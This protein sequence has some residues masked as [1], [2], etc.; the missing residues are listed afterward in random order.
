MCVMERQAST[1]VTSLQSIMST[2]SAGEHASPTT[3]SQSRSPVSSSFF[4]ASAASLSATKAPVC[5]RTAWIG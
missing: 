1:S 2:L 5:E 4:Q 3:T